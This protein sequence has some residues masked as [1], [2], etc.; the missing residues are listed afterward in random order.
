MQSGKRMGDIISETR[1]DHVS[2]GRSLDIAIAQCGVLL[3]LIGLS[4]CFDYQCILR[5]CMRV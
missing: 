4:G 2:N 3:S 1:S 5:E